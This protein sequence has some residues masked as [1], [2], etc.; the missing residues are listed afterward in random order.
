[1]TAPVP[2][3]PLLAD[4][5]IVMAHPDDEMLWA[6]S[7]LARVGKVIIVYGDVG[8]KPALSAGRIRAMA[9]F[10][11]KNLEHLAIPEAEVF[12]AADWPLPEETPWGLAVARRP[13]TMAGFSEARYRE[14]HGRLSEMLRQRLEGCANVI[15]HSP[16]GEYG[17]EEHVQV[18]RAVEAAQEAH[19]FDIWVPGYCSDKSVAL[20]RRALVRLGDPT[21]PLPTDPALG[22]ELQKLYTDNDCWTWF[23]DHVW[24]A[25]EV[26]YPLG[27]PGGTVRQGAAYPVNMLEIGWARPARASLPRRLARRV[28][29]ATG[30]GPGRR[31]RA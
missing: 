7:I 31:G 27:P 18:L 14:N 19:G 25:H 22:A 2:E 20:M 5:A 21:P 28:L 24:P 26:F 16:W 15:T 1:M 3:P 29:R 30:R 17:H 11:L 4:S 8:S 13:G 12:D 10:P 23:D 6:S 9:D